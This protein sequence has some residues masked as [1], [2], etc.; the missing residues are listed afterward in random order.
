MGIDKIWVYQGIQ[1][2]M[3]VELGV[4]VTVVSIELM[5]ERLFRKER[6]RKSLEKVRKETET[7]VEEKLLPRINKSEPKLKTRS[8]SLNIVRTIK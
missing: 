1:K 3:R 2:M 6:N 8:K 4:E 7:S 5:V